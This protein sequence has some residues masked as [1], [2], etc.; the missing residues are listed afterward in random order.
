MK[1]PISKILELRNSL[2]EN[3]GL[4]APITLAKCRILSDKLNEV[5]KSNPEISADYIYNNLYLNL[6][7][8]TKAGRKDHGLNTDY[9]EK[10]LAFLGVAGISDWLNPPLSQPNILGEQGLIGTYYSYVKCNSGREDILV[11]PVQIYFD[12]NSLMMK[13]RGRQREYLGMVEISSGCMFAMISSSGGRKIHLIGKVGY[14][15]RPDLIQCV[16]SAVSSAGDP[17]A[18]KELLIRVSNASLEDGQNERISIESMLNSSKA[19]QKAIGAYFLKDNYQVCKIKD[20]STFTLDD[21]L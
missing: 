1:F 11:S 17:I 5:V 21:I 14:N 2:L 3:V 9:V 15:Q 6:N 20:I 8:A 10:L 12:Q 13:L 19:D 16:Y 4:T 7:K 18:G